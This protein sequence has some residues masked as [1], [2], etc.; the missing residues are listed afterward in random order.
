[1]S[2]LADTSERDSE[3]K[4]QYI[5]GIDEATEALKKVIRSVN[6][7]PENEQVLFDGDIE[8][9]KN[10][11]QKLD[12]CHIEIAVFGE[13]S[14]GKSALLNA[15][16]GRGVFPIGAAHGVTKE[17]QKEQWD[18]VVHESSVLGNSTIRLVDTPGLNEVDGSQRA[19]MAKQM[20]RRSDIILF[21]VD[22]DLNQVEHA[23][24]VELGEASKPIILV[25]NKT[26]ILSEQQIKEI[27]E[28]ILKDKL[29]PQVT[30]DDLIYAAADPKEK[31]VVV[32]E[33]GK[34][35]MEVR[36]PKP[37]VENVKLRIL[38]YLKRDGKGLV[39]LN[40]ALFA[41]DV[42]DKIVNA[43]IEVQKDAAE[44]A[45]WKYALSKAAAVA[46][47]PVPAVDLAGG[48]AVD[49]FMIAHLG[50]I[51]GFEVNKTDAT[52][53]WARVMYSEFFL[54]GGEWLSHV[55]STVGKTGTGGGSTLLTVSP[56]ALGAAAGTFV[57]GNSMRVY[58]A[59]NAKWGP[60]GPKSVVRTVLEYANTD[61]LKEKL[62]EKVAEK[63][64]Q[65]QKD[66][67]SS[68]GLK[69]LF[70]WKG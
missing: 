19:E 34:E 47:N 7:L 52:R 3:N 60:G 8:E 44:N 30:P 59:N 54:F 31:E 62:S 6:T 16:L 45:I 24:L 5:T 11:L 23:A 63:I 66:V 53:L 29:P 25:L 9:L 48:V 12:D 36:Q 41:C 17:L 64:E 38:E 22:S 13:V 39:A 55:L 65:A 67:F 46:L 26:D 58:F 35:R 33:D 69:S 14:S 49:I 32:V 40:A 56:Q 2:S 15:L 37:D 61:L 43:K 21:V 4:D 10:M 27:R 28:S 70:F 57:L 51:Y 1:M 18:T 42:N 20:S 50:K 68:E